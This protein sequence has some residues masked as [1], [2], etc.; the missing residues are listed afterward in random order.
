[1]NADK[2]SESGRGSSCSTNVSIR[3]PRC[4]SADAPG[5]VVVAGASA[6]VL[7]GVVVNG[8]NGRHRKGAW[9]A[10]D[11]AAVQDN[12]RYQEIRL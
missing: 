2:S 4:A 10:S 5:A 6:L 9:N 3:D 8:R 12:R 1:M 7:S 11:V